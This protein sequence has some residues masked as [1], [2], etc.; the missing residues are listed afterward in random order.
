MMFPVTA[1]PS[2]PNFFVTD[3]SLRPLTLRS[4]VARRRVRDPGQRVNLPLE[5]QALGRKILQPR[6]VL[7]EED[8][9]L[10]AV[11]WPA[12]GEKSE[13]DG[14]AGLHPTDEKPGTIM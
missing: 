12:Q 5:V 3:L 1:M 8:V 2:P 10:F 13:G 7:R 9:L 14:K 4:S 11:A 6:G